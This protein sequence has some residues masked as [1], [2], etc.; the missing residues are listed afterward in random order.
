[1]SRPGWP[2]DRLGIGRTPDTRAIRRAYATELKAI[3]P[4]A[5][6][7][8]FLTLRKAYERALAMAPY[9]ATEPEDEDEEA[10][11]AGD[12]VGDDETAAI[13]EPAP[14]PTEGDRAEVISVPRWEPDGTDEADEQDGP[15]PED[16]DWQADPWQPSVSADPDPL[17]ESI[18]ALYAQLCDDGATPA[19][20]MRSADAVLGAI[21]TAPLDRAD[22]AE[23]WLCH[24]LIER[25]PR[26]DPVLIT[27]ARHFGWHREARTYRQNMPIAQVVE[28]ARA[29]HY[30]DTNLLDAPEPRR[31]WGLLTGRVTPSRFWPVTLVDRFQIAA[32]LDR[33]RSGHPTLED[34]LDPRA[35]EWWQ[36]RDR[37]WQRIKVIAGWL[38]VV[39]PAVASAIAGMMP[40]TDHPF[41]W[42]YPL[43]AAAMI[44]AR[45]GYRRLAASSPPNRWV[46]PAL[47][48]LFLLLPAGALAPATPVSVLLFAAA[49]ALAFVFT[50]GPSLALDH[51][52]LPLLT[53][54]RRHGLL[55]IG[56]I[57]LWYGTARLE[58]T[59]WLQIAL[60]AG[61]LA[62]AAIFLQDRVERWLDLWTLGQR[63]IARVTLALLSVALAT[64]WLPELYADL[65]SGLPLAASAM[66]IVAQ[67]LLASAPVLRRSQM[68]GA[69]FVP[70]VF[71]LIFGPGTLLLLAT[72][73][74][75]LTVRAAW[76]E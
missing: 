39:A 51:Q 14:W 43:V 45:L 47:G 67:H 19:E 41:L 37:E 3:D 50:A 28:R 31:A 73:L 66:A 72:L 54:L 68:A 34:D 4:E 5:D 63:R 29:A 7:D 70:L 74:F 64:V 22:E 60:P 30:R 36:A 8:A 65:P 49:A 2:W 52:P 25:S 9:A 15:W 1:M 71:A 17:E 55:L 61:I 12:R 53:I 42:T 46:L 44:L 57:L 56:A 35:I 16:E 58:W 40:R 69:L 75:I 18:R 20:L 32:L 23:R 38:L 27:I 10:E 24:M 11:E 26:S 33:I 21:D 48:I 59:P 6:P 62:V 76:H 13:A